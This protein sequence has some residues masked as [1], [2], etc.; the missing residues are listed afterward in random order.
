MVTYT[1]I[2]YNLL[3]CYCVTVQTDESSK[4]KMINQ[5]PLIVDPLSASLAQHW[6]SIG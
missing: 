3:Q 1:D 5:Y 4:H 2:E 6:T